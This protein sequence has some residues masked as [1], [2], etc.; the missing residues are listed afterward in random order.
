MCGFYAVEEW[1]VVLNENINVV[2]Y[3]LENRS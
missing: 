1:S 2:L 3:A